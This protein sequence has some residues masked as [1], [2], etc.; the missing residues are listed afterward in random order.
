MCLLIYSTENLSGVRDYS[1][2]G[3]KQMQEDEDFAWKMSTDSVEKYI[4]FHRKT[5]IFIFIILKR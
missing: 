4:E 2:F 5:V 1:M 3:L